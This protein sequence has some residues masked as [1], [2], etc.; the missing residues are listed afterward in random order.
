MGKSSRPSSAG[1]NATADAPLTVLGNP[2]DATESPRNQDHF[3]IQR[4][5]YDLSYNK[6]WYF[7][8]WVAW[9][10]DADDIGENNGVQRSPFKPDEEIPEDAR[11]IT[12]D[13]TGEKIDRG[14]NCPSK[15][16]SDTQENN[17]SVFLM[18]NIT[19]QYHGMNGG[20]WNSFEEYCRKMAF[21]GNELYII[22]G[23]GFINKSP[24]RFLNQKKG[25]PGKQIAIPDFGWKIAIILPKEDGNDVIRV[26]KNTRI[27]AVMMDNKEEIV[28]TPWDNFITTAGEIEQATG[29]QF[30]KGLPD[31]VATAL[32]QK[33]DEGANS[34]TSGPSGFKKSNRRSSGGNFGSG[35]RR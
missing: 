26:D 34:F 12:R 33:R 16:R 32:K 19:P 23:H 15:D 17:Q 14:H 7:P 8:N 11:V 35:G 2:D 6:S 9:H 27:I 3:L 5:Q 29:L 21:E 10:L 31:S 13:Y 22:C 30:F 25:D 1:V 24:N 20:P 4:P 18:S 28:G